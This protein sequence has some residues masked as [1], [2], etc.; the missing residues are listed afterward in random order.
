VSGVPCCFEPG[1]R[2]HWATGAVPRAIEWPF[3]CPMCVPESQSWH[4]RP[5]PV[6]GPVCPTLWCEVVRGPGSAGGGLVAPGYRGSCRCPAPPCVSRGVCC[7]VCAHGLCI[8]MCVYVWSRGGASVWLFCP[9][10]YSTRYPPWVVVGVVGGGCP[11]GGTGC[12]GKPVAPG[13]CLPTSSPGHGCHRQCRGGSSARARSLHRI[14]G[15][16]H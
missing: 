8:A 3:G 12:E 2:C 6:G 7:C 13:S 1:V 15:V 11:G 4:R 14:V 10:G 16:P 9:I 5:L